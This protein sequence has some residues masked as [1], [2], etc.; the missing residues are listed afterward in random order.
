MLVERIGGPRIPPFGP[1]LCTCFGNQKSEIET[2]K[3]AASEMI[4]VPAQPRHK[5][6][7]W[8]SGKKKAHK[9]KS[10]WP[11]TLP[12]TGGSPDREAR[13]ESFMHYPRNP[14]NIN[15]FVR[16]P[17]REDPWPGDRK[18][19]YVQKF[20]VPFLLP[21]EAWRFLS[22]KDIS[23]AECPWRATSGTDHRNMSA[24]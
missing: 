9:H 4:S 10:F 11:V 3:K 6:Q 5:S 23:W 18:K 12:V 17:D 7:K 21:R 20:Y 14:R 8:E 16:I 22:L 13:G 15:L 2:S 1:S 24:Q 19:F